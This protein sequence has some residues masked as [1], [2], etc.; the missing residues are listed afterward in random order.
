MLPGEVPGEPPMPLAALRSTGESLADEFADL[1][2]IKT[3]DGTPRRAA[4]RQ[5]GLQVV[6]QP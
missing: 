6:A 2:V 3:H 1:A 5:I 4:F